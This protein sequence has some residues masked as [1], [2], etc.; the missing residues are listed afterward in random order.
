M[1]AIC[2][3]LERIASPVQRRSFNC[4]RNTFTM[5]PVSSGGRSFNCCSRCLNLTIHTLLHGPKIRD[6]VFCKNAAVLFIQAHIPNLVLPPPQ[7]EGCLRFFKRNSSDLLFITSFPSPAASYRRDHSRALLIIFFS[8]LYSM[9]WLC[10]I[11]TP[12]SA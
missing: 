1:S 3:R 12:S 11:H 4:C 7:S 9:E 10:F 8:V 2:R 5:Q 6:I